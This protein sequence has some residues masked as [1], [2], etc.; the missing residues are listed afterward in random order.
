MRRKSINLLSF[1]ILISCFQIRGQAKSSESDSINVIQIVNDFYDWYIFSARTDKNEENRPTIAID[2]NGSIRLDFTEYLKNLRSF[3]FSDSLISREL[4][5][6]KNC[7]QNLKSITKEEFARF[8]DISDFEDIDCD[9]DNSYKWI[10]GQE[11]C[12]GIR[13]V[14]IE[15]LDPKNYRVEIEYFSINRNEKSFWGNATQ[16]YLQKINGNW[17]IIDIMI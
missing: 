11:M 10:G 5:D 14:C 8:D 1:L 4:L 15:Y 13:I 17:K 3:N 9:F 12:D 6:Y 2:T 7:E 16:V